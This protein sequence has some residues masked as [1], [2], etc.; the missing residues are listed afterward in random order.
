MCRTVRAGFSSSVKP[1]V[2]NDFLVDLLFFRFK[3]RRLVCF[4]LLWLVGFYSRVSKYTSQLKTGICIVT[5]GKIQV[6]C[7][8]SILS[9]Q[10]RCLQQEL[11]VRLTERKGAYKPDFTGS[12]PLSFMPRRQT[13]VNWGKKKERDKEVDGS[14][15]RKHSE[16]VETEQ[17]GGWVLERSASLFPMSDRQIG[18]QTDS[19]HYCPWSKQAHTHTM[20]ITLSVYTPTDKTGGE[21]GADGVRWNEG[22]AA[23]GGGSQRWK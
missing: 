2:N 5:L 4:Q 15:G 9:F 22:E 20:L 19:N 17:S 8:T 1:K 10:Q 11:K 21:R 6:C 14:L 12:N 13:G 3:L 23:G 18:R 7:D 16:T